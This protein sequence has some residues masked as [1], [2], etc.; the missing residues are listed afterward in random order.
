VLIPSLAK[1]SSLPLESLI[2]PVYLSFLAIS[3]QTTRWWHQR[4]LGI[5]CPCAT[6]IL[7]PHINI[8]KIIKKKK[9][10]NTKKNEKWKSW[11]NKKNISMKNTKNVKKIVKN[12]SRRIKISKV[13]KLTGQFWMM[14]EALLTRKI[15]NWMFNNLIGIF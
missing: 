9:V 7:R 8:Q 14:M 6:P 4:S 10:Q 3:D 15:Q 1:T 13:D 2:K 12:W 5:V 11:K